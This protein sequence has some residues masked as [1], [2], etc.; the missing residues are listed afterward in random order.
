MIT[1]RTFF[2]H[3]VV[4]WTSPRKRNHVHT[5]CCVVSSSPHHLW[6]HPETT[7]C[8][9]G[10]Y[11]DIAT[12]KNTLYADRVVGLSTSFLATATTFFFDTKIY[13]FKSI[14]QT[15]AWMATQREFTWL[16]KV[17]HLNISND[18]LQVYHV[19]LKL[20]LQDDESWRSFPCLYM[21]N[22]LR[23]KEGLFCISPN[24]GLLSQRPGAEKISVAFVAKASTKQSLSNCGSWILSISASLVASRRGGEEAGGDIADMWSCWIVLIILNLNEDSNDIPAPESTMVIPEVIFRNLSPMVCSQQRDFF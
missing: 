3:T 13:S 7:A 24:S 6:T 18:T 17:L 2:P 23:W 11:M 4:T 22:L 1:R 20:A 5:T 9:H 19:T 8:T 15:E 14:L 16:Y 12:W 10:P 21:R